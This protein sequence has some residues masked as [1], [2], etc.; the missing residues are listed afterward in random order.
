MPIFAELRELLAEIGPSS[1]TTLKNSRGAA[2]TES[3]L[4]GVFQKAKTK[5]QGFDTSLRIHDLRGTY[6]TWLA[7]IGTT[8]Q[9]V[10][11]IIGWKETR[12]AELRMR[13]IDEAHIVA[14][15]VDRH[16][17]QASL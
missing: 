6:A 3:G 14:S 11:R 16:A 5:A 13:Y 10:G 2:W 15:M 7:T 8:D 17:N 12:V 9:E 1:G 4:G